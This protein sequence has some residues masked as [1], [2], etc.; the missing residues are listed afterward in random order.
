MSPFTIP[1]QTGVTLVELMVTFAVGIIVMMIAVPSYTSIVR[2]SHFSSELNAFSAQIQLA[3]AEALKRNATV[4]LCPSADDG[5]NCNSAG[6]P[7]AQ[8][9]SDIRV[10]FIDTNDDGDID[11]GETILKERNGSTRLEL[12]AVAPGTGPKLIDFDRRGLLESK[13]AHF[14]FSDD[15]NAVRCLMISISGQISISDGNCS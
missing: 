1:R 10:I 7:W 14:E 11:D 9:A 6:D 5:S 3:R 4:T 8:T 15:Q 2:N 12:K 13:Y